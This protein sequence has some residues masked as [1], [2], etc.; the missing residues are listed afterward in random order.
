MTDPGMTEDQAISYYEDRALDGQIDAYLEDERL[1]QRIEDLNNAASALSKL[2]P[3]DEL[4]ADAVG[5]VRQVEV[6]LA[7]T[8]RRWE[9]LTAEMEPVASE[10]E[11]VAGNERAGAPVAVGQQYELVPKWKNVY[12]YN[13]PAILVGVA[14]ATGGGPTD[15]LMDCIGAGAVKL[16]WQLTK[17]RNYLDAIDCTYSV[18]AHEVSEVS[19]LDEAMIGKVRVR[20]GVTRVPL[21]VEEE[22]P[23]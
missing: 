22:T 18:A 12:S 8:R 3:S 15:A 2:T 16:T 17:L 5:V 21:V 10:R 11:R 4:L 20:D 14:E 1:K 23:F 13:T 19:G 6:A 9:R 7:E